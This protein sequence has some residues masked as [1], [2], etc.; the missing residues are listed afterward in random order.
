M[1][2]KT[3]PY[4][5]LTNKNCLYTLAL[6]AFHNLTLITFSAL[7]IPSQILLN[8]HKLLPRMLFLSYIHKFNS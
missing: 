4:F 1:P 8:E 5:Y 6:M 3:I 7:H 2:Q